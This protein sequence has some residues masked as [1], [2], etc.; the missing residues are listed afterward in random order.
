MLRILPGLL[1]DGCYH[2][3][4]VDMALSFTSYNK[5]RLSLILRFH[6]LTKKRVWHFKPICLSLNSM[7]TQLQ[8]YLCLW[9][10]YKPRELLSM[11]LV[12]QIKL[13]YQIRYITHKIPVQLVNLTKHFPYIARSYAYSL[14]EYVTLDEAKPEY[15]VKSDW[16]YPISYRW[17]HTACNVALL[18]CLKYCDEAFSWTT[19]VMN[20]TAAKIIVA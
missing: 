13:Q 19:K 11:W 12:G 17:W 4:D 8:Y 2:G 1:W 5:E 15:S 14:W 20:F 16:G 18:W 6:P 10:S 9:C 7:P 3:H